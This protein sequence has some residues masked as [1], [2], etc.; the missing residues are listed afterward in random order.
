MENRKKPKVLH[1]LKSSVYS[2][3][4]NVVITIIKNLSDEFALLYVATE[5]PVRKALEKEQIPFVLLDTFNR[6]CLKDVV[7]QYQPDIIHA[8]DFSATV[9]CASLPGGFR[10]ISHLHYDP[11]W[12]KTWNV[13]TMIY[14]ACRSRIRKLLTVSRKSFDNMVFAKNF[15][16]KMLTVGNP[17]DGANIREQA[18]MP[19]SDLSDEV[20]NLIFVGRF[21]EQKNPQRFIR[22]VAA[23]RDGGWS[24]I[25][26][27]M[28][29]SGELAQECQKLITELQ[30]QGN[31][32][33]KGFQE[34]PYPYIQRSKIL[35]VTSRWEG[36]GLVAIEAN[37]LGV[38]VLSTDNAGCSEIF[39][40]H[41]LEICR[42]D[43]EFVSRIR[44]LQE[45]DEEYG[46]WRERSL[47][48][49]SSFDN[50]ENYMADI[51]CVYRNEVIN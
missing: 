27:W 40:E 31:I 11:P 2:G 47:M 10:L 35:C 44:M 12:V 48:R 23:L 39:G 20:C 43:A 30:L 49:G 26:A 17:I 51:A 7:K 19:V 8:H 5:G 29:G 32:E 22:L 46:K 18:D 13:K 24:D 1:V 42:N 28:L 50:I 45:S 6:N 41:A 3:A 38:P 16:D 9:L 4:E 14:A 34:N 36:F 37:M 33:I 21:V 25:R 15:Q